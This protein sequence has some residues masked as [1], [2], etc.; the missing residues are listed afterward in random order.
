MRPERLFV[1]SL[2][3]NLHTRLQSLI[4]LSPPADQEEPTGPGH[5]WVWSPEL[6]PGT[7][8]IHRVLLTKQM[9]VIE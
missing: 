6:L 8:A 3:Q 9:V 5:H 2:S 1:L 4:Y 7:Q